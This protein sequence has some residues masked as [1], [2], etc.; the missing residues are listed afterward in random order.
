MRT[1]LCQRRQ[2][3]YCKLSA[4]PAILHLFPLSLIKTTTPEQV[5]VAKELVLLH[6]RQ[7]TASRAPR[8]PPAARG[9]V[10][11]LFECY[12]YH[13]AQALQYRRIRIALLRT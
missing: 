1:K 5:G 7:G 2:L 4:P 11:V 10:A 12:D 9:S 3:A 13:T 8:P 6:H